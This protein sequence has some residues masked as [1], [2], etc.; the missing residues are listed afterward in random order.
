MTASAVSGFPRGWFMIFFSKE[1]EVG[2]TRAMRYFGQDLA[3]WR[4]EDGE[5]R[6]LDAYC[7][8][9]GAHL[10]IGGKVV[11]TTIQCP[12]HAW[13]FCD[14]GTCVEIPYAQKIPPRAKVRAWPVREKN[15]IVMIWH[16]PQGRAPDFDI[17]DIPGYGSDKWLPWSTS[18]YSIKTHPRE[19]VDNLAD[20][21]HFPRVHNTAIDEFEF[22]VDGHTATQ[23]VKGR[24]FLAKGGVDPFESTTTYHGPGYLLMRMEG[25]LSNWMLFAHTPIEENLLD[26]RMAVTLK[27]MGDRATTESYVGLY[28]ENLKQG[29]E[30]D[31]KIW[32][33]KVYREP[34][35]LCEGDGPIGKLRK[36][37]R[38]FYTTGEPAAAE[39]R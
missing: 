16:D 3:A 34:A 23:R 10:A 24:A 4:G 8:H 36:W 6:V 35:L 18:Q 30:D 19:I 33:H 38:Q 22:T 14:D 9:L 29:F 20:R 7:P 1:L 2:Q 26:L 39:A 13:R 12:F 17:P 11:G 28:L 37:Y 15:G 31:I 27:V 32:E 25:A 5:V 21:S